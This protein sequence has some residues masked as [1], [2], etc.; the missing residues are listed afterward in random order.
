MNTV[1]VYRLD[2]ETKEKI[3]LGILVDRRKSDRGAENAI[4]MLRLARKEF[5]ETEK[6]SSSIFIRY[7]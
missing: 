5:A 1:M 3:P 4:G 6:E 2:Q 7:E